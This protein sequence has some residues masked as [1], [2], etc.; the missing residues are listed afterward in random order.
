[1]NRYGRDYRGYGRDYRSGPRGW[2]RY[3]RGTVPRDPRIDYAYRRGGFE[4]SRGLARGGGA[5]SPLRGS[6]GTA[7]AGG[8]GPWTAYGSSEMGVDLGGPRSGFRPRRGSMG[9]RGMRYDIGY[10][11]GNDREWF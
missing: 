8:G 5:L 6:I 7:R 9:R 4:G 1:M 10:G 2:D 3:E 11:I